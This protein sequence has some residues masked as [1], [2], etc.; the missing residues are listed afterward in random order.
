MPQKE[1][2]IVPWLEDLKHARASNVSMVVGVETK[3][4]ARW[5]QLLNFLESG[6]VGEFFEG[7]SRETIL[8]WEPFAGLQVLHRSGDAN[9]W[10]LIPFDAKGS[11]KSRMGSV[12][13]SI[14]PQSGEPSQFYPSALQ[15]QKVME[16]WFRNYMN[17]KHCKDEDDIKVPKSEHIHEPFVSVFHLYAMT[18]NDDKEMLEVFMYWANNLELLSSGCSVILLFPNKEVLPR[19]LREKI[20][21]I[22]PP[23]STEDERLSILRRMNSIYNDIHSE[24]ELK[25]FASATAGLNLTQL[26]GLIATSG[27]VTSI[28]EGK[29]YFSPEVLSDFKS[30]TLNKLPSL[31]VT[32]HPQTSFANIGGYEIIKEVIKEKVIY[33]VLYPQL[34]ES[35][36]ATPPRGILIVG[37]PGTGKT[38][39]AKALAKLINAPF[40][41]LKGFR[42]SLYGGTETVLLDIFDVL[43]TMGRVI[44]F[45][46]EMAAISHRG[47]PSLDT[48]G[49]EHRA[50]DLIISEMGKEKW[51]SEILWVATSNLPKTVAQGFDFL[52]DDLE[53]ALIRSGRLG[54]LIISMLW[55]TKSARRQ[56]IHVWTK[57]N[58]SLK[59]GSNFDAKKIAEQT[60]MYSGADLKLLIENAGIISLRETVKGFDPEN[61]SPVVPTLKYKHIKMALDEERI[62]ID[63]RM[64][65]LQAWE[66][67]IQKLCPNRRLQED[68]RTLMDEAKS[69]Y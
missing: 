57:I 14:G 15:V 51:E 68:I 13:K 40:C 11:Y 18:P 37:P 64:E 22:K 69:R 27:L 53:R 23:V 20:S 42:Q 17:W 60:V 48:A 1:E 46:D 56:I 44:L 26:K 61:I 8:V 16:T 65:E 24:H 4:P 39:L 9:E 55:P 32:L 66:A 21:I 25:N 5:G 36:G 31:E 49:A 28:E 54:D 62:E 33:P 59:L 38:L 52:F 6:F 35:V 67:I 10:K 43:N 29:S 34:S 63:T 12:G 45:S 50:A 58:Q 3:D 2:N 7:F 47:G 19:I 41:L 30:D